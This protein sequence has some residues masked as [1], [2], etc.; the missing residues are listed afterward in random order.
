MILTSYSCAYEHNWIKINKVEKNKW[1]FDLT[2]IKQN[3][4]IR[5]DRS[6][7]IIYNLTS[8]WEHSPAGLAVQFMNWRSR[9]QYS[10]CSHLFCSV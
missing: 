3:L 2:N 1:I 10:M 8:K 5:T 4:K 6:I 9:V 7:K